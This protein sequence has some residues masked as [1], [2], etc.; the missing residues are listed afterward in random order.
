MSA[1]RRARVLRRS[2]FMGSIMQISER[3]DSSNIGGILVGVILC[4]LGAVTLG[5]ELWPS[6]HRVKV[7]TAFYSDDD[8]TTFY[9]D[10]VFNFP[11]YDH[12][13]KEAN[14]AFVYRCDH[15]NFVGFLLRYKPDARKRLQD[16]Y[17]N[18][19]STGVNPIQQV[20]GLMST[21]PIRYGG[22]EIK[23]P[24]ETKWGPMPGIFPHIN[25]P[26]GTTCYPVNP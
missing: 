5:Y 25:S 26:D 10:S 14:R 22:V 20:L 6:G 2:S 24:G 13:G 4:L 15:G 17:N 16:S 3:I 12:N 1:D 23:L 11:P 19:Q 9:T 21:D 18:A 8:G 7:T